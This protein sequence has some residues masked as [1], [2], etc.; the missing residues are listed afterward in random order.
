MDVCL[1]IC[2]DGIIIFRRTPFYCDDGNLSD[3]DGCSNLCEIEEGWFCDGA[4]STSPDICDEYC[5]DGMK[6][7][8]VEC[9]DGNLISGD[10]C[11]EFCTIE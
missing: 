4:S 2:G 11:S 5:G 3:N 9:D 10:G 6:F 7:G 1:Q 8:K